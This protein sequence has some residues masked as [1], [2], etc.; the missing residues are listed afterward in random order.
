MRGDGV[1]AT[2]EGKAILSMKMIHLKTVQFFAGIQDFEPIL[3][4]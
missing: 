1:S 4:S 2:K 3:P